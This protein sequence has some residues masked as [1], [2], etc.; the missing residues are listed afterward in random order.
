MPAINN[1]KNPQINTREQ[2]ASSLEIEPQNKQKF[3]RALQEF[4]LNCCALEK[5]EFRSL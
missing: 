1:S 2:T 4:H 3:V 5:V